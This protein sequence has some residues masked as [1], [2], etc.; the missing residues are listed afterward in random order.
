M[1]GTDEG[2]LGIGWWLEDSGR[3]ESLR[4]EGAEDEDGMP[5]DRRWQDRRDVLEALALVEGAVDHGFA[6]FLL[7]Q[8][9]LF[10]EHVWGFSHGAEIAALLVAEHQRPED[11]WL[12]WDALGTSFDTWCGLPHQ[13]IES[14]GGTANTIAYVTA[15]E[16]EARDGLLEHLR[17][18]EEMTGEEAAEF[19]AGRREYYATV[20]LQLAADE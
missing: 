1:A 13:L 3:W 5:L 2:V 20:F 18:S 6:R 16:H 7:E 4:F 11:V 19:I 14:A 10:H 12:L 15:S 9:I 8:E 17:E